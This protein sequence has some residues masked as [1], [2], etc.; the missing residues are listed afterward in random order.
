VSTRGP[1][2]RLRAWLLAFAVPLAAASAAASPT[3]PA[4]ASDPLDALMRELAAHP[5]GHVT[6]TEVQ[7]LGVLDRP[8]ESSGELLY[9]APDRL[10]K[11]ILAPRPETLVLAHGVLSAT[12]G[13]HTHTMDLAAWPQIA[14]LLESLRATL[15]GDRAALERIFSVELEGDAAHWTLRLTPKDPEAARTVDRVTITG[16]AA[17]LRTVE[18][19]QTDGDRSLLTI[20]AEVAP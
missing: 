8:L 5:S 19:L 11:R 16:E 9:Q 3:A 17:N 2:W 12:R 15:T 13:K 20:G 4:A 6:F 1:H 18:I 14:P 10:E 7:H